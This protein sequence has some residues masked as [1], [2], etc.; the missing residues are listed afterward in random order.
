[1]AD[2]YGTRWVAAG[3][4]ILAALIPVGA[5]AA[6]VSRGALAMAFTATSSDGKF[7]TAGVSGHSIGAIL[8]PQR[9][10]DVDGNVGPEWVLEAAVGDATLNGIC[11]TEKAD[12]LGHTITLLITS[13]DPA[14]HAD[15]VRATVFDAATYAEVYGNISVNKNAADVNMGAIDLEGLVGELGIEAD[16]VKTRDTSGTLQGATVHSA[17][18]SNVHL[19]FVPADVDCP[20]PAAG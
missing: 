2:V 7:V 16:G 14:M 12:L 8:A 11:L 13:D 15:G 10:K 6:A 17:S 19:R 3:A 4:V 20:A 1:M 9:T 5:I 18:V